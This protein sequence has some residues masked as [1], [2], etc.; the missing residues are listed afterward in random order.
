MSSAKARSAGIDAGEFL[1]QF[2]EWG[3]TARISEFIERIDDQQ[4][5]PEQIH[6]SA[7]LDER[8]GLTESFA[9]LGSPRLAAKDRFGGL[10]A[11]ISAIDEALSREA[12]VRR[13]AGEAG[14][15]MRRAE[16]QR[17]IADMPVERLKDTTRERI[18]IAPLTDAGIVSV[19]DVFTNAE[20]LAHLPGIG[21]TTAARI[22][23][24]AQTL[25]QA[26]Y[27]ETSIR[28]DVNAP[29]SGT[30]NLLRQLGAWDAIRATKKAKEDLANLQRLRPLAAA[31]RSDVS[32][33]VVMAPHDDHQALLDAADT[34]IDRARSSTAASRT[35]L[36]G[37]FWRDFLSRPSDYFVMIDELGFVLENEDVVAGGLP[38]DVVA[39]IRR[40]ELETDHL[41]ASLRG[42]QS[43]AA[44][45]ALVQRKVIIGDE[46]GLG[47]T[48]EALAVL[49]HLYSKGSQH[50]VVVCPAAV[51]TNWMREIEAKSKLPAHRIHGSGRYAAMQRWVLRGGVAVTTYE[52]LG[53]VK[54]QLS[55]AVVIACV[56]VDEA[57]YVKNPAAQRSR[58]TSNLIETAERAI[59][60]T[61]TPLE[62][63]VEEFR[64]LVAYVRPDLVIDATDV[65]PRLFRQQVA[66][67]YLRRTTEDVLTELPEL[68]EVNEWIPMSNADE[69]AYREAVM[70]GNFHSM[71]QAAMLGGE[72]SAKLQRLRELVQEA[73]D[74]DRKVIVFS[75]F[76][77]VLGEVARTLP[78]AVFGPLTGSVP[79]AKRQELVDEF[80]SAGR[81]AVLVS[82]IIAGGVG[83]NIQAASMVVICEPQLK[84]T[85][86]W[87]AIARSRRMGQLRSVQ[88][89]RLLSDEG[90]DVRVTQILA[91]KKALFEDFAAVSDAAEWAPEAVDIS[92]GELVREVVSAE[93]ERLLSWQSP[94]ASNATL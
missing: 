59:L 37:D 28:I 89:H 50:S 65:R 13:R 3:R 16:A 10:A 79:A 86:E 21:A 39:A 11:A 1:A 70:S 18:R 7:V 55:S 88:V 48:V 52:S 80:S 83:L 93:R 72:Q 31:L 2:H 38:E 22:R 26:T 17:L 23:G 8:V 4:R 87:Q 15:A 82:Q 9:A 64:N 32:H 78:G 46:M 29:L 40:F 85:I 45:F 14:S 81:G 84:P 68:V 25:W 74:N 12:D 60:L 53:W 76:L 47:K 67:A 57:H 61:G 34:V 63:R 33:L 19:Q 51:V 75:H 30:E 49:C 36:D 71:R 43:F 35:G 41:D 6:P 58:R 24:A 94:E 77:N 73:E 92:D 27:E 42:Y 90:A 62:N 91:K 56:V 5:A 20:R 44:R 66:P 54:A 69:V